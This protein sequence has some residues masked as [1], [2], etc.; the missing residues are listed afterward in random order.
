[1]PDR[2]KGGAGAFAGGA[3]TLVVAHLSINA[4]GCAS[5]PC[6]A[7]AA[8]STPAAAAGSPTQSASNGV[9]PAATTVDNSVTSGGPSKLENAAAPVDGSQPATPLPEVVVESVGMH[10]GGGKNDEA[11]KAPFKS[12]IEPH[13]PEFRR[14]YQHTEQPGK[15]G[16]FG[17]DLFIDRDGGKAE[18]RQP[19]T[20]MSGEKFRNCVVEV[21]KSIDFERPRAGPTVI[22]Y[23]LRFSVGGR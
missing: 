3:A 7:G 22:S 20:G 8:G 1:M 11:E 18:V 9:E 21:F 23:S 19:R 16:T 10:I 12:A 13:F 4:L 14:C 15:G 5:C 2:S 6:G 17:V